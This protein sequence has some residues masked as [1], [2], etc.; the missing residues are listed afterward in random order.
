MVHEAKPTVCALFPL[1]RG[2][3]NQQGYDPDKVVGADIK[4]IFTAP[5]CGDK[6]EIHTVREWL[7]SFG[8]PVDDP[9]FVKWQKITVKLSQF[10]REAEKTL[11]EKVMIQLWNYVFICLYLNYDMDQDFSE[12]FEENT[13]ALIKMMK[14]AEGEEKD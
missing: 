1:G 6:A 5:G 13:Q 11:N 9:F 2:I 7:S 4:Y 8:I 10:L 12:Q 3:I 14:L